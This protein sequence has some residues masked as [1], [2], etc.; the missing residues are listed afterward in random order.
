M[1]MRRVTQIEQQE[2][3]RRGCSADSWDGVSVSDCFTP[4]QLFGARL[5]GYV[6]IGRG[7]QIINSYVANYS[8]GEG[9][10]VESVTRLE[11]RASSSFGVG[12]SVATINE[13][14]GRGVRIHPELTSQEAYLVAMNRHR[15]EFIK[16][17][18][19]AVESLIERS[20][21]GRIGVGCRIVGV[22]FI[23]EVSVGD[24]V[25]IEGASQLECGTILSGGYVGV[26][27]RAR[28]FICV[29]DSRL[30]T[31]ASIERCFIGERAIVAEGFSA[32]DSLIFASSHLER[33]EAVSIFAAPYTVSH[34]RSS[35]L[36]AGLFSMF[37]AGSG[38]NQS[39]HLFKCGAIHQAIHP[40]GC[41]FASG[42]YVMAPAREGA[43]TM[44]KG[45][46]SKHHD[47]Y[48]FPY[49]YLIE[50]EGRS[51]LMPGA[52]LTSYGTKRDIDKWRARDRRTLRR[53]VINFEEHNPYI[54]G[55]MIRAVNT[56]HALSEA[57]P[58]AREYMHERVV[59]RSSQLKRGITLYNKAIAASLGA[60]LSQGERL[61]SDDQR[62]MASGDWMDVGGAFLSRGVVERAFEDL[63][64]IGEFSAKYDDYAH[65][66]AFGVVEQMLG[67]TPSD[68]EIRS[69]IERARVSSE[70][71]ERQRQSDGAKDR[72]PSMAVGY[73]CD[74]GDEAIREAEFF[75]VQGAAE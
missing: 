45:S 72:S 58:D 33:G 18:E 29:E 13:N 6:D 32:V 67:H 15:S 50:S 14:G 12:T 48:D 37:N 75:S 20:E 21:V 65:T 28:D 3:L 27:V 61:L 11:C 10:I 69:I 35:L 57:T 62:S 17:R 70:E 46:H 51:L 30:D 40:R 44:I 8:I 36:I 59:I 23:R 19:S 47:T 25:V 4:S 2:L 22:R 38:S 60:M 42:A 49:S 68:E 64:V 16:A 31:G 66:W 5:S 55:A 39:N 73:G 43:F 52:N 24:G 26:D 7:A 1:S 53:D 34:H 71:L 63:S 9:S 74:W 54:T 41:K 56:L